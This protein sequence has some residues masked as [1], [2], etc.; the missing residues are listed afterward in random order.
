EGVLRRVHS[1]TT[2]RVENIAQEFKRYVANLEEG[3]VE[4]S[5]L[6]DSLGIHKSEF[7]KK[8]KTYEELI[9]K[10]L[11][12]VFEDSKERVQVWIPACGTGEEAMSFALVLH[13]F[14]K[15]N[16]IERDLVINAKDA[17]RELIKSITSQKGH[18]PLESL[19]KIPE[20]YRQYLD[21]K[22]DGFVIKPE[23][24]SKLIFSTGNFITGVSLFGMDLVLCQNVLPALKRKLVETKLNVLAPILE[25]IKE[26]AASF[27]IEMTKVL[28]DH[29][30][31]QTKK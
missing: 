8:P 13:D 18:Y 14:M 26:S 24:T 29:A 17:H 23:V 15:E 19:A 4:L 11:P 27:N 2:G 31:K 1:R 20:H 5:R 25:K 16:N 7:F 9:N 12:K 21:V 22:A 10:A 30:I 3:P 28:L 6:Y